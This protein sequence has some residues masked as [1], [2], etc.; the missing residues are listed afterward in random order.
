MCLTVASAFGYRLICY[1]VNSYDLKWC[2]NAFFYHSKRWQIDSF[3]ISVVNFYLLKVW[4]CAELFQK[5]PYEINRLI[6][7]LTAK[8]YTV[9][10]FFWG[11]GRVP[12]I[13]QFVMLFIWVARPFVIL[14]SKSAQSSSLPFT[15]ETDIARS[16]PLSD[17]WLKSVFMC[18]V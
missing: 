18:Q 13:F 6:L 16:L 7:Q 14:R 5:K 15:W 3:P 2:H 1:T 10:L 11:G 17:I 8:D 4:A 12:Y 9:N